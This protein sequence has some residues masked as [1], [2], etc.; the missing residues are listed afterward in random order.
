[1]TAKVQAQPVHG[2]DGPERAVL[3]AGLARAAEL[4][5]SETFPATAGS[6]CRD[7]AF[8]AICPARGAGSVTVQ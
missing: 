8:V 3:R 7:C 1:A 4:V 5:R 6:H 2:D